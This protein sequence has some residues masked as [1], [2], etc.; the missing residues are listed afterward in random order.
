MRRAYSG[1]KAFIVRRSSFKLALAKVCQGLE[2]IDP[3]DR[4]S[5]CR[6]CVFVFKIYNFLPFANVLITFWWILYAP[7][8]VDGF[9]PSQPIRSDRLA[10]KE[11]ASVS[12]WVSLNICPLMICPSS[13]GE[14]IH[15]WSS[16]WHLALVAV[17]VRGVFRRGGVYRDRGTR[18]NS[19]RDSRSIVIMLLPFFTISAFSSSPFA[20]MYIYIYVYISNTYSFVIWIIWQYLWLGTNL[21]NTECEAI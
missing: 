9:W 2:I 11:K 12:L 7:L 21:R 10:P 6:P 4:S 14:L 1:E 3:P 17:V 19:P 13:T 15:Y 16:R 18:F 20:Y 8:V 5:L